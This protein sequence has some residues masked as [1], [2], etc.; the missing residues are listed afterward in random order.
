MGKKCGYKR[1]DNWLYVRNQMSREEETE[2]QRHLLHCEDCRDELAR[3]R[4]MIRSIGKKEQRAASFR[5]WMIAA[6]IACILVG[7]GAYWHYWAFHEGSSLSPSDIHELRMN[8]PVLHHRKD[9]IAPQDTIPADTM[10]IN[11][12]D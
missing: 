12:A 3:L 2:F 1:S 6:S 11:V 7:G 4:L 5:V 8:L 9:S 10:L